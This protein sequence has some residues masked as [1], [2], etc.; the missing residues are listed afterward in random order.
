MLVE[1]D[2]VLRKRRIREAQARPGLARRFL[3]TRL[4]GNEH[5]QRVEVEVPHGR[6]GQS[7]VAVV[8]RV[9]DAAEDAC[10]RNSSTSSPTSTSS[11][12]FTPAARRARSSSSSAG[13]RP[14]TR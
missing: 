1:L 9:E 10:H 4:G 2:L 11:P 12:F 6:F 5:D 3:V 13:G 7:D 8:R 14:E